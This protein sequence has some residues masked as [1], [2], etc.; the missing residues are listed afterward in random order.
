MKVSRA[1]RL[2][3]ACTW[4]GDGAERTTSTDGG[5]VVVVSKGVAG[6]VSSSPHSRT[7]QSR[8]QLRQR[9]EDEREPAPGAG[10]RHGTKAVASTKQQRRYRV[11]NGRSADCG[12]GGGGKHRRDD[13]EDEH[14][15]SDEEHFEDRVVD[16]ASVCR[17]CKAEQR[18]E[19]LDDGGARDR[20]RDRNH[21]EH[22]KPEVAEDEEEDD[23][24]TDEEGDDEEEC[25]RCVER[26]QRR[27]G[28]GGGSR[29]GSHRR[30][31]AAKNKMEFA[32]TPS[33]SSSA[34]TEETEPA[35]TPRVQHRRRATRGADA[36]RRCADRDR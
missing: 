16:D 3:D 7:P 29:G 23:D 17:G 32:S 11:V 2:L 9:A 24:A 31:A 1:A 8:D 4:L 20:E 28:G 25:W 13:D 15:A 19:L 12:G 14:A 36:C 27:G 18:R 21:N 35:P 6:S 10:G 5:A 33:S 34:G 22:D 30:R 26:N